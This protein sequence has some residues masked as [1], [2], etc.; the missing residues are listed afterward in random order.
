VNAAVIMG[1][2]AIFLARMTILFRLKYMDALPVYFFIRTFWHMLVATFF[3]LT[4][5]FFFGDYYD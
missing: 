2:V 5:K 4:A 3:G 1:T